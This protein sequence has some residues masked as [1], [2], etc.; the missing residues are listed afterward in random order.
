MVVM[1]ATQVKVK[2]FL[3]ATFMRIMG[4]I[5]EPACISKVSLNLL[6]ESRMDLQ[7]Q[8][9]RETIRRLM[10]QPRKRYWRLNQEAGIQR[11]VDEFESHGI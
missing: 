2:D 3:V 9:E 6:N 7:G 11:E 5:M 10:Q 8:S 4:S 1:R